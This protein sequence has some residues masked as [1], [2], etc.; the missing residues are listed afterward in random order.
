MIYVPVADI[1]FHD[2]Y[3]TCGYEHWFK[4]TFSTLSIF[5]K[6]W[7][8]YKFHVLRQ[9]VRWVAKIVKTIVYGVMHLTSICS[10]RSELE[11]GVVVAM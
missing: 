5:Y 3:I 2:F 6:E 4:Y 11:E 1:Q 7:I 9:I 10:T 8:K